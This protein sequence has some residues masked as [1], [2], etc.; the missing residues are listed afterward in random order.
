MKEVYD[1]GMPGD[2]D[3]KPG[4][5]WKICLAGTDHYG[6]DIVPSTG[7]CVPAQQA[8]SPPITIPCTNPLWYETTTGS[9]GRFSFVDLLPGHYHL[10]EQPHP[11]YR[12]DMDRPM[13]SGFDVMCC[14]QTTLMRNIRKGLAWKVYQVY[15]GSSCGA[16]EFDAGYLGSWGDP[17]V[18][19]P[20][21]LCI[22]PGREW[23]N[24]RQCA[25]LCRSGPLKNVTLRK[26]LPE[27]GQCYDV[28]SSGPN[29]PGFSQHGTPNVRLWWPLMY[30]PPGT[31]WTLKIIYGT[32]SAVR[33]PGESAPG[34]IHSDEWKWVVDT[35]IGRVKLFLGL[36]RQL[37]FGLCEV[38][39][40]SNEL[41]Y[42]DLIAK[43]E[44]VEAL[45]AAGKTVAAGNALIDFEMMVE[46]LCT[47]I[48]PDNA[49]AGFAGIVNTAENPVCCKLLADAEY[50]GKKLGILIPAK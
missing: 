8:G 15:P 24:Y 10:A 19:V 39:L 41:V 26:S 47:A 30:D 37:P 44:E 27:L 25:E 35:D 49:P 33:F 43:L 3:G 2:V 45:V 4:K 32:R 13:L 1:D 40:L 17:V 38:P 14:P 48:C 34:Y 23:W 22:E 46:D 50:I 31:S 16:Q 29:Y 9:D 42:R 5:D 21:I 36:A 28:F 18:A 6:R 12:L 11:D 20:G 7:I